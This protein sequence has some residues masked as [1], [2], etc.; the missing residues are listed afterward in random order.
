MQKRKRVRLSER[1]YNN[2]KECVCVF[3]SFEQAFSCWLLLFWLLLMQSI[4]FLMQ[5]PFGPAKY[6]LHT[7]IDYQLTF[8]SFLLQSII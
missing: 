4:F 1:E 7:K 6:H 2:D 5:Y 3:T 8:V